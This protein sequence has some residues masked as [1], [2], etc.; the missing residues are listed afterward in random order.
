MSKHVKK[1]VHISMSIINIVSVCEELSIKQAAAKWE[2]LVMK[3]VNITFYSASLISYQ[4][5]VSSVIGHFNKQ[6]VSICQEI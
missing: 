5:R 1:I 6:Q 4:G 3:H 2:N